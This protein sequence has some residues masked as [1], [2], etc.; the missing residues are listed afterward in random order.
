M[1]IEEGR[2]RD[3]RLALGGVAHKPWRAVAAERALVGGFPT[4]DAFA[5]AADVE[6]E[7]AVPQAHTGFKIALAK[8][9]IV[10][11]LSELAGLDGG[12]A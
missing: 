7:P 2:I 5:R 12:E 8:R 9:T 6:L 1:R 10:A 4:S 3:V 11:T